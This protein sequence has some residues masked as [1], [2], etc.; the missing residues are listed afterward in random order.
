VTVPYANPP[1][2][3]SQTVAWRWLPVLLVLLVI[4]QHVAPAQ[5]IPHPLFWLLTCSLCSTNN[6]QQ[7]IDH[8]PMVTTHLL[9]IWLWYYQSHICVVPQQVGCLLS[10]SEQPRVSCTQ[11]EPTPPCTLTNSILYPC[12]GTVAG[13]QQ[14]GSFCADLL[15]YLLLTYRALFLPVLCSSTW[16]LFVG[17]SQTALMW[18][19]TALQP[20]VMQLWRG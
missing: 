9:A 8:C 14:P 15:Q 13:H 10:T 1:D 20:H 5:L 4:V 2:A 6:A 12:E 3:A 17:T 11:C 19:R 16:V 7:H 18:V